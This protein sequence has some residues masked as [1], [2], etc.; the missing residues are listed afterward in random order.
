MTLSVFGQ[1]QLDA[2]GSSDNAIVQA[3]LGALFYEF[4]GTLVDSA[5]DQLDVGRGL[6]GAN[7][8]PSIQTNDVAEFFRKAADANLN[9]FE[10]LI[11][12]PAAESANVSL[13]TAKVNF[14]GKDLTYAL[15]ESGVGVVGSLQKYFGDAASSAYAG[16]GGAVALY[17]RTA[18]LLAKYYSLGEVDPETLDVK[19][20][21]NPEAFN[22]A[23]E[24]AQSQLAGGIGVLQAKQVNPMIP[25]AFNEIAGVDR[26]GT[27]SD[28]L[29]ALGQYWE[30]YLNTRVLAYLGGFAQV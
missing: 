20:I 23:I 10:S 28:K 22:A 7:L 15:A 1:N 14:A 12:A 13:N 3:T 30:G 5:R 18:G 19:D 6:G 25:V 8:G 29:N 26:E 4:A 9:V 27:A 17:S 2:V 21:Q 24:L 11:V 16:I